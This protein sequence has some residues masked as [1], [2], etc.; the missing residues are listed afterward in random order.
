MFWSFKCE[1]N[2]VQGG[3]LHCTA[4]DGGVGGHITGVGRTAPYVGVALAA[5]IVPLLTATWCAAVGCHVETLS[6]C[7]S[8]HT[9]CCH[10]CGEL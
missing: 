3:S 7:S 9:D 1:C 8:L 5:H 4:L 6:E 10:V 2:V